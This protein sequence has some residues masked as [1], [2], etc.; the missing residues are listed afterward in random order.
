MHSAVAPII[1]NLLAE[2][3]QLAAARARARAPRRRR[4]F[5]RRPSRHPSPNLRTP[6]RT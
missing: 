6:V 4:P 3:R 2:E 1:A 5:I